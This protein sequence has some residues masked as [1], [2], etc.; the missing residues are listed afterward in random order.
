MCGVAGDGANLQ[1]SNVGEIES[2]NDGGDPG[3]MVNVGT[4][5]AC[6]DEA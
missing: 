3:I 5:R 6:R 1:R 2:R 4:D